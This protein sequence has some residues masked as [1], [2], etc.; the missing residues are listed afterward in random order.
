MRADQIQRTPIVMLFRVTY[1]AAW[2]LKI[3]VKIYR[4][5]ILFLLLYMGVKLGL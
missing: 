5:V 3:T 4:T 2:Y 1:H